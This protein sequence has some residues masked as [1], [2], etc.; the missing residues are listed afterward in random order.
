MKYVQGKNRQLRTPH[1][2]IK[3]MVR[4]RR[5]MMPNKTIVISVVSTNWLFGIGTSWVTDLTLIDRGLGKF[6]LKAQCPGC[7]HKSKASWASTSKLTDWPTGRH[8][9]VATCPNG[10]SVNTGTLS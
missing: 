3:V 9:L 8:T 10:K 4:S 2:S 6:S 7:A 1:R 5:K